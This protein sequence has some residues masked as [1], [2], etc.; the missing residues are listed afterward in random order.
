MRSDWPLPEQLEVPDRGWA[1]ERVLVEFD[2]PQIVIVGW[3]DRCDLAVLADADEEADRW[4]HAPISRTEERAV[5]EGAVSLR[6][7]LVKSD[8]RITDLDRAGNVIRSA[9]IAPE[10][11]LDDHLPEPGA[12]LP[13]AS[14]P[15][16]ELS[17]PR[18]RL[19]G[20]GVHES[21]VPVRAVADLL[22]HK[23]RLWNALAQAVESEPTQRGLIDAAIRERATLFM[24]A[25]APGSFEI[26]IEPADGTLY[27]KVA[28]EF[29]SLVRA[30][31]EPSALHS[32]I[33][34]LQSRVR[35]A[36]SK[37]L[38]ALETSKLE[39][40]DEWS[41]GA[42]FLSPASAARFRAY[43]SEANPVSEEVVE[44]VGYF[45]DYNSQSGH[46][47]LRDL[48][49]EEDFAGYVDPKIPAEKRT[50]MVGPGAQYRVRLRVRSFEAT[51]PA[52]QQTCT[53]VGFED[54]SI[55]RSDDQQRD[56]AVG[57]A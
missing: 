44:T 35:S 12:L 43:M 19:D 57:D 36:Y 27:A 56:K 15:S 8:V 52:E 48:A 7:V 3:G 11:L 30:S 47:R 46:F 40:L 13:Y 18:L 49:A 20:A 39:V 41:G 25:A 14:E 6:S 34:S 38:K 4:L 28:S 51:D 9:A 53:L 42:V 5:L 33:S 29:R 16:S 32:K 17:K 26:T 1:V 21:T 22:D 23:Q 45:L 37:Y 50:L 2:G 54:V 31:D 10:Q 55:A 24:S